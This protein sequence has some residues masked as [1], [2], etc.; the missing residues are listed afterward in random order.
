LPNNDKLTQCGIYAISIPNAYSPD[1]YTPKEVELR[2]NVINPWT[3]E[4][5]KRKWVQGS[6][7]IYYGLAGK[8]SFRS[9]NDRLNDLLRHGNGNIS[10]TGPH[11]GGEILWQL[12]NYEDFE[13]WI[14]PT[15][16]PP[17]PRKYEEFILITF[18]QEMNKL[19]FANSQF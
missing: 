4:N 15:G 9:L 6:E 7:L 18:Y 1:Y 10:T 2:G 8:N 14:L 13:I 11:K 16:L 3:I 19:P 5:L 17:E 12:K